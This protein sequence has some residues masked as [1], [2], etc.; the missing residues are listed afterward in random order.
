MDISQ[1]TV[2]DITAQMAR[3]IAYQTLLMEG[4]PK[5]CT[6]MA[7]SGMRILPHEWLVVADE[8]CR[9]HKLDPM[10]GAMALLH[11]QC[12]FGMDWSLVEIRVILD[13]AYEHAK[14][15]KWYL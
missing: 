5:S 3:R 7:D 10:H 6:K 2:A 14:S 12:M 4:A 1:Y 9:D 15:V 11:F 8:W 13:D